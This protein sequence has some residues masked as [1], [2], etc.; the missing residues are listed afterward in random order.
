MPV[1]KKFC[2][3]ELEAGAFCFAFIGLLLSVAHLIWDKSF[4][5]T[6][7]P[8][9]HLLING[10]MMHGIKKR[11]HNYLLP[12]FVMIVIES[13]ETMDGII[14]QINKTI[15]EDS[16]DATALI[17]IYIIGIAIVAFISLYFFILFYSLYVKI[18]NEHQE[19]VNEFIPQ[20]FGNSIPPV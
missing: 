2:C 1:L 3:L 20:N 15:S 7:S 8:F 18:K 4:M 19:H 6:T 10:S 16:K 9:I 11:E 12:C 5:H 14:V 13:V 17:V